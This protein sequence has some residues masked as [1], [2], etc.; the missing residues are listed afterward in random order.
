MKQLEGFIQKGQ[1]NMSSQE[2]PLWAEA[3]SQAG[4][5]DSTHS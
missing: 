2:V 3:V 5:S 1:E 4:T